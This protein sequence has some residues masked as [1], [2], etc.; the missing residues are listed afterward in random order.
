MEYSKIVCTGPI[1]N[2]AVEILRPYGEVVIASAFQEEVLL[3]LLD[4]A[5]GLVVRGVEGSV[6]ARVINAAPDLKV[7][8][9][10]GVGY[11]NVDIN[12]ATA[13]R[14]PVV[15]TP[16]VNARAI[17]EAAIALISTLC[18]KVFFWD[19]QLKLGNWNSRF[20]NQPGDLDGAT[21]GIIGF[22]RIG[23]MLAELIRPFNVTILAY[24]PYVSNERA[25]QL[26]V[27][28]VDLEALLARSDFISIHAALTP[29]TQGLINRERLQQIK[30]GAYIVNLARGG[31]I[32]SLDV[33]YEALESGELGGVGLDVFQPE[34]PD[35]SHPIF[36]LPNCVTSP[37][38]LGLT[39]QA[40]TKI[41]ESMAN[42]MAAVLD[43]KPPRHVVNPEVFG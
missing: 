21:L 26:E 29:E 7:I 4:R 24:D 37:H 30:P 32:E 3:P 16:G 40:L 33:L 28:L 34:P 15:Y 18:K 22:G 20:Q 1:D 36:Q 6:S 41:F 8:G 35:V 13:L 39:P 5:I 23:Q 27:E 19:R 11:D 17:A 25:K 42:D 10:S 14:I 31:L 12:A 38:A 43:G 2:A 9:R